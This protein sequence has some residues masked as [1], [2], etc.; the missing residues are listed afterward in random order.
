MPAPR[1]IFR[2]EETVA[3][4]IPR[5]GALH[6]AP[7]PS[8]QAELMVALNALHA[9]MA[10]PA[11]HPAKPAD[12]TSGHPG[13]TASRTIEFDSAGLSRIAQELEAVTS[14]TAQATQK[15]LGAAEEIDQMAASLSAALKSGIEQGLAQ[16][17][18][19]LVI[20]IFEACNFQDLT[21]QRITKVMTSLTAIEDRVTHVLDEI[22]TPLPVPDN[23]AH[24]GAHLLYGPRL[25]GDG[26]HITQAEVDA[27]FRT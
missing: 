27:L 13:S 7:Q 21:A 15:I 8:D 14:G 16:D 18:S 2:I 9:M 1:K 19:D 4:H 25:D 22:K 6:A 11:A 26:G 10:V 17:I 5:A 24:N 20:R 23:T 12:R 3:A